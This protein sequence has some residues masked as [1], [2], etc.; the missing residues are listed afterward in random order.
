MV[1][2]LKLKKLKINVIKCGID[3]INFGNDIWVII[4][5]LIKNDYENLNN[6]LFVMKIEYG[7]ILFLFIGDV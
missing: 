1:D 3:L 7:K 6:Y 5:F 4:F 2:V